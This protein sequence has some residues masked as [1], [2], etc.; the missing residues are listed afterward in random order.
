[1]F[2]SRP[3]NRKRNTIQG[4]RPLRSAKRR[5]P[6][7]R[8]TNFDL[9]EIILEKE[10]QVKEIAAQELL[11]K[12][13]PPDT[14]EPEHDL[15][16]KRKHGFD[17][18]RLAEELGKA[19]SLEDVDDKLAET[20]FG[21]EMAQAAAEVAAMVAADTS[22]KNPP[23][24]DQ[25]LAAKP[26]A[27]AQA[28]VKPT[29]TAPTAAPPAA[30]RTAPGKANGTAPGN[31][32]NFAPRNSPQATVKPAPAKAGPAAPPAPAAQTAGTAKPMPSVKGP[33]V[34]ITLA[35]YPDSAAKTA[36]G[37]KS[38]ST[39]PDS[40]EEQFG[41]SMTATLKALSAAQMN[42]MEEQEPDDE[43]DDKEKPS[44]RLF[45]FFRGSS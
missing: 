3:R 42:K 6:G 20:L 24:K 40:I 23:A 9:P 15:G 32:P 36:V 22:A 41:T 1:M 26:A 34:E 33:A 43:P 5:K 19:R 25:A 7:L 21:E 39:S 16:I 4:R 11:R 13:G 27:P 44:R 31:A 2:P 18:D 29:V 10:L 12:A 8:H 28:A 45:G 35:S 17:L 14:H 37:Q 30:P 38:P